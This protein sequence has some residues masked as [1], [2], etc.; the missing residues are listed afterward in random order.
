[1]AKRKKKE[2]EDFEMEEP[3]DGK[4]GVDVTFHVSESLYNAIG[5]Y[6]DRADEVSLAAAARSLISIGVAEVG[7][8]ENAFIRQQRDNAVRYAMSRMKTLMHGA[9]SIAFEQF[10]NEEMEFDGEEEWEEK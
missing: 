4:S 10:E 8:M 6:A 9:V 7:K 3:S 2:E 5:D 1:M